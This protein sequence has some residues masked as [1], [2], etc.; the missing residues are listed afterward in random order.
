MN[1][2]E[3]EVR[4]L[5]SYEILRAQKVARNQQHLV[6]LGLTT[7]EQAKA[8]VDAAFGKHAPSLSSS[9]QTKNRKREP[10]ENKLAKIVKE[11]KRQYP[12][13]LWV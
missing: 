6:N 10:I 8:H 4:E 13:G 1:A 11:L 9:K 5:S 7:K 3:Q 2:N 12:N